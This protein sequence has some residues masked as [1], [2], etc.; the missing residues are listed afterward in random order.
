VSQ[1]EQHSG[2][3]DNLPSSE[4][5]AAEST[6]ARILLVEDDIN[7]LEGVRNI[8][9][10]DH[11][12]V[13]TAENGVEAL[14]ILRAEAI[15]PDLILS[16]IMMPLMDGIRLLEEVRKVDGWVSI[17]F[18]YLT[19]KGEEVDIQKGK[20]L[21][22]DDYVVKPYD[23]DYLLVAIKSR[24]DRHR[25]LND[26]YSAAMNKL[27]DNILTILNHEFRTPL[28][29]VVAY[30]DMLTS[31]PP[32]QLSTSDLQD[33]LQGVSVGA[34]RL[35]RLVENFILLVELETSDARRTYQ[36][37]KAPIVDVHTLLI[38]AWN[39]IVN[40][41]GITHTCDLQ[42]Q[43]SLPVFLGDEQFIKRALVQLLD[44]AV[45]FSPENK[46]II[47]GARSENNE[48]CLWVQDHG[49][50]IPANEH[51][52]ILESFYQINRS[53]NEDQGA[54]SGLAIVKGIVNLHGGRI[55]ITSALGEGSILAIYLP[56][57]SAGQRLSS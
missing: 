7:L 26:Y 43:E 57:A 40:R 17:P 30:A 29:F 31:S 37:R 25:K 51:R 47:A 12:D 36:A 4:E 32:Q 27:K 54:G 56:A 16:D 33:Y 49:R 14:E 6:K 42:I 5:S 18:I 34:E 9:E 11:Y 10:L 22:V 53:A 46:Q 13:L 39:E 21:G 19:A 45:K 23:P 20:L 8:L 28:T 35:R 50:G 52:K 24:L 41:G 15:P 55:T 2:R 3:V 48:V 38:S 1:I 44:N